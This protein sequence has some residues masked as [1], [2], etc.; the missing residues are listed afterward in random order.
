MSVARDLVQFGGFCR[1]CATPRNHAH[2]IG[3]GFIT[4]FGIQEFLLKLTMGNSERFLSGKEVRSDELFLYSKLQNLIRS[5]IPPI[6]L[7]ATISPDIHHKS[8]TMSKSPSHL[9]TV[10]LTDGIGVIYEV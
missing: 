3:R 7:L 6:L 2:V 9:S 4:V 10:S 5:H 1:S 8:T